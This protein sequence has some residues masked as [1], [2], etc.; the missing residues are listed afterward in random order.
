MN[1]MN[2]EEEDSQNLPLSKTASRI[3]LLRR[4]GT[5]ICGC[6]R[7]PTTTSGGQ[8]KR[9][10]FRKV[11]WSEGEGLELLTKVI[12][13]KEWECWSE[14]EWCVREITVIGRKKWMLIGE[15]EKEL[16]R[17]E[18]ELIRKFWWERE[19]NRTDQKILIEGERETDQ[20]KIDNWPEN[21]IEEMWEGWSET[22]REKPYWIYEN[23]TFL[24][25]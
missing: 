9:C 23:R 13:K 12:E 22:E 2:G 21:L 24:S 19:R 15:G 11:C 1:G 14:R 10:C 16:I 4:S 7:S 3:L 6:L 25:C 20:K 5:H 17:T 8:K 18:R